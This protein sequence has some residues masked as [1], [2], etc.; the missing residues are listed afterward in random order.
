MA[1][2]AIVGVAVLATLVA[3]TRVASTEAGRHPST[4]GGTCRTG[5]SNIIA[6]AMP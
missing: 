5:Q 1:L 6:T 3:T 2:A 4:R